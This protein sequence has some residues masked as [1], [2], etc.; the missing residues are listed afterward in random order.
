MSNLM[1]QN[2]KWFGRINENLEQKGVL[3]NMLKSIRLACCWVLIWIKK[4]VVVIS[5][6]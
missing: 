2:I 3:E 4:V 1:M 5:S 6:L